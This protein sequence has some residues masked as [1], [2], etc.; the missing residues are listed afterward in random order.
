MVD[1]MNRHIFLLTRYSLLSKTKNYSWNIPLEL[2]TQKRIVFEPERLRLHENLFLNI[3]LPSIRN[4][5]FLQQNSSSFTY[6]IFTSNELPSDFMRR[7]KAAV[8]DLSYVKIVTLSPVH[9]TSEA[10][11]EK[12]REEV[13]RLSVP[14]IY[15]SARLD[16]DDAL[17]SSY[18]SKVNSYLKDE[19]CGF[20]LSFPD[21]VRGDYDDKLGRVTRIS[22]FYSP[23]IGLGL[24][25]INS[26]NSEANT[27]KGGA[28]SIHG[29]RE[30][31]LVD[32]RV[33]CILD[34]R[35][36]MIFRTRHK[37]SISSMRNQ[38][39][40]RSVGKIIVNML[41][42]LR[43]KRNIRNSSSDND[44]TISSE[45]VAQIRRRFGVSTDI[46][47]LSVRSR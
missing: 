30:H 4:Q 25:Y 37:A 6:M 12:V 40:R 23:M 10:I 47:N 41:R 5:S 13:L 7:I 36:S 24:C 3:C 18:L 45:Y 38:L 17:S 9:D 26:S 16:D 8:D 46:F 14:T 43:R 28:C 2:D 19:F 15:A 33:P 21:G 29:L 20:A 31:H 39:H 11:E 35:E 22:E 27:T 34:A 42:K 32:R 44:I 1:V